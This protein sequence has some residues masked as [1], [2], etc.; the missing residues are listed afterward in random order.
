MKVTEGKKIY[1]ASDNHLGIPDSRSSLIRE[2]KFVKWLD[3]IKVNA[4]SIYLLGDLFDFW[5]EY[6]TVVPKGFTRVLGKIAEISDSGI[7]IYFFTGNHDMWMHDY[8]QLELGVKIITEPQQFE[9]NQQSFFIGHGDGLGPG[10]TSY[11]LMKRFITTNKFFK[12]CFRWV[13]PDIGVKLGQFLSKE[14]KLMST[15]K[16]IGDVENQWLTQYCR[17]KLETK[18][19]DYFIFGHSHIPVELNLNS[20][21]KYIN[22]GDWI[23]NFTYAV[24]DGNKLSLKRYKD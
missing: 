14:K 3:T 1:F 13:H 19:Y 2:K 22:L 10:D 12:W 23:T 15:K 4:H 11:K 20:E 24:F 7:P 18:H 8:F 5:F 21:S 16:D 9:I 17:K 6:K